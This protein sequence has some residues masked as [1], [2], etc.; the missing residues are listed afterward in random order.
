MLFKCEGSQSYPQTKNKNEVLYLREYMMLPFCFSSSLIQVPPPLSNF[1]PGP[2]WIFHAN[3]TFHWLRLSHL[4]RYDATTAN[5]KKRILGRRACCR[6]AMQLSVTTS[7]GRRFR[8]MTNF[9]PI[10]HARQRHADYVNTWVSCFSR[11]GNFHSSG[12]TP[13][14]SGPTR[15]AS[16][17]FNQDCVFLRDPVL[18]RVDVEHG[19][20]LY[21]LHAVSE[22]SLAFQFSR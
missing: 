10:S 16:C 6:W 18:L 5:L 2:S 7:A 21:C 1:L 19:R 22:T 14:I 11:W 20:L 9:P 13:S 4:W 17:A 8:L 12:Q 3:N 15:G